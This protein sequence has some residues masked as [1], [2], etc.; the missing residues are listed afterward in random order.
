MSAEIARTPPSPVQTKTVDIGSGLTLLSPLTRRG[1]GPGLLLLAS[2]QN[3]T[4][5][6]HDGVPSSLVKWAEEG[7]SVVAIGASVV[8]AEKA[9]ISQ[10]LDDSLKALENCNECDPKGKFGLVGMRIR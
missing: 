4:L 2:D 6:I 7:Y 5:D 8:K 3:A 1:S 9:N 10:L